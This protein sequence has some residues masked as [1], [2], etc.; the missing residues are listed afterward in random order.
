MGIERIMDDDRYVIV[1]RFHLVQLQRFDCTTVESQ[2]TISS[3]F[4]R[5]PFYQSK[6]DDYIEVTKWESFK[7]FR[8]PSCQGHY[9]TILQKGH[10]DLPLRVPSTELQN[11]YAR[12]INMVSSSS[13]SSSFIDIIEWV[14]IHWYFKIRIGDFNFWCLFLLPSRGDHAKWHLIRDSSCCSGARVTIVSDRV[15]KKDSSHSETC[16]FTTIPSKRSACEVV[17][18]WVP[19]ISCT[20]ISLQHARL[21][22][23]LTAELSARRK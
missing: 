4:R 9:S 5:G 10:S 18:Q 2:L 3:M 8:G 11:W 6:G 12:T 17:L 21:A 1:G 20:S 22:T 7:E 14:S 19:K 15:C 13:W 23:R 16:N